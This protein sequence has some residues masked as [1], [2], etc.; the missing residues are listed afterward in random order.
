MN[1]NIKAILH[2]PNNKIELNK[3]KNNSVDVVILSIKITKILKL[4]K[5]THRMQNSHKQTITN[6]KK[7]KNEEN[8]KINSP[9]LSVQ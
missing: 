3:L 2:K 5:G 1:S 9:I 6:L 7:K 4:H 8:Q